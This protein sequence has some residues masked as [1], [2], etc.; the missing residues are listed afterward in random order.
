M[1]VLWYNYAALCI[2]A[3]HPNPHKEKCLMCGHLRTALAAR[4]AFGLHGPGRHSRHWFPQSPRIQEAVPEKG[5]TLLKCMSKARPSRFSAGST[6]YADVY[7]VLSDRIAS[8][9]L[10][11]CFAE[12]LGRP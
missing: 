7:Y 3:E 10:F 11:E 6:G 4:L 5:P 9:A 8:P 12:N 2:V 1:Y